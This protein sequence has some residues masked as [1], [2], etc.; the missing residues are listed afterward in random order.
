MLII[1]HGGLTAHIFHK[2]RFHAC[3]ISTLKWRETIYEK[4]C[5]IDIP[6]NYVDWL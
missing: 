4:G 5:D 6:S 3:W 2:L 1:A